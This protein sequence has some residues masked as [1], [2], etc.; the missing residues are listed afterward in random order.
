MKR[1]ETVNVSNQNKNFLAVSKDTSSSRREGSK[2][3]MNEVDFSSSSLS[4]SARGGIC[5]LPP[6]PVNDSD[7]DYSYIVNIG[8][9]YAEDTQ[10]LWKVALKIVNGDKA[11]AIKLLEDPEA[12]MSH[13]EVIEYLEKQEKQTFVDYYSESE[14]GRSNLESGRSNVESEFGDVDNLPVPDSISVGT[15]EMTNF[16]SN[17]ENDYHEDDIAQLDRYDSSIE[18]YSRY[19]YSDVGTEDEERNSNITSQTQVDE[20]FSEIGKYFYRIVGVLLVFVLLTVMG[21]GF[22]LWFVVS[23]S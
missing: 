15:I 12:L 23:N 14:S 13:T 3:E 2:P 16:I 20:L 19:L 7:F 22:S 5:G 8:N 9:E 17:D 4:S 11:E 10:T 21:W 18:I 1:S 6:E